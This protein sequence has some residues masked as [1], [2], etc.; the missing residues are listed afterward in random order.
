M[1][2]TIQLAVACVAFLVAMTGQVQALNISVDW[3]AL[4]DPTARDSNGDMISDWVVRGGGAFNG[5]INESIWS[6]GQFVDTRPLSTWDMPFHVDMRWRG[7]SAGGFDSLFWVNIDP[8]GA[9]GPA[10][11][12]VYFSLTSDGSNQTLT[13]FHKPGN[14]SSRFRASCTE[15]VRAPHQC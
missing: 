13:A 15:L 14:Y 4:D 10:Y 7:T 12:P 6:G 3:H 5:A 9:G 2:R 1:W 11:A 8:D